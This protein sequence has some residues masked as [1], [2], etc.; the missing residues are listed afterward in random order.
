VR[1][2]DATPGYLT[3]PLSHRQAELKDPR[4]VYPKSSGRVNLPQHEPYADNGF[5]CGELF[6]AG[7]SIVL[8]VNTIMVGDHFICAYRVLKIQLQGLKASAK[9]LAKVIGNFLYAALFG[10]H[11]SAPS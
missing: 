4:H 10:D 8:E 9:L 1:G 11:L 7:E 6:R 3:F 2:P 5:E